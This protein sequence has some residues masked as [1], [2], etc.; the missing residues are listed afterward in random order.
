MSEE[1]FIS[2]VERVRTHREDLITAITEATTTDRLMSKS[3]Q[4]SDWCEGNGIKLSL[5]RKG[6]F[7]VQGIMAHIVYS[8]TG[9]LV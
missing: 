6:K 4:L 3:Y 1:D 2:T 5:M 7:R 8:L 9:Q